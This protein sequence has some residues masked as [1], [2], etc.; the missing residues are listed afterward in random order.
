MSHPRS[1][2]RRNFPG[3]VDVPGTIDNAACE[4][5]DGVARATAP[6]VAKPGL[7]ASCKV[8]ADFVAALVLLVLTAPLMVLAALLEKT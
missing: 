8:V 2:C 7:Y 3:E 5:H 6:A 4:D 1:R